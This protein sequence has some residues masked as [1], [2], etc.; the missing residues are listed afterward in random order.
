MT[1]LIRKV[2][3]DKYDERSIPGI[4]SVT[5]ASGDEI[6]YQRISQ[7]HCKTENNEKKLSS[8]AELKVDLGEVKVEEYNFEAL[9]SDCAQQLSILQKQHKTAFEE[10]ERSYAKEKMEIDEF[11]KSRHDAVEEEYKKHRKE[12]AEKYQG[13]KKKFDGR[14]KALREPSERLKI[15]IDW[16]RATKAAE[17][18]EAVNLLESVSSDI[19]L[20]IGSPEIRWDCFLSHVQKDSA[21]L[22]RNIKD[23][24]EREGLALWYDKSVDRVDNLGMI[25]GVVNSRVF[26]LIL[27]TE[28]FTRPYCVFEY[29][30]ATVAGKPIITVCE[31]DPRYG[32][33]PISCFKLPELFKHIMKH[34][35]IEINRTY[36]NAFIGKL[37]NRIQNTLDWALDTNVKSS[38][39]KDMEITWLSEELGKEGRVIGN[40]LFIA[41]QDG[42]T[43]EN[44]HSKCDGKGPTLTVI[45]TKDGHVFGGFTSRSWNGNQKWAC[46][47]ADSAWL[48]KL[49]S[50]RENVHKRIDIKPDQRRY[51]VYDGN[52]KGRKSGPIF[53]E[54]Y[55][56]YV[57]P[58]SDV[59]A[60]C[61]GPDSYTSAIL[62]NNNERVFFKIQE[63]EIFQI[64]SNSKKV[65]QFYK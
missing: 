14:M 40:R 65:I 19:L 29:C 5:F 22:C 52:F 7:E 26:I 8:T 16:L 31:S 30:V 10:S 34:E 60:Y 28:F 59:R 23:N 47:A 35:L 37:V 44:F 17:F 57:P 61:C 18:L 58:N 3:M 41:S 49:R 12:M 55:D 1:L 48:F 24:L 6:T 51:A 50:D 33:G 63:M 15:M 4:L 53:G 46:Y 36:W 42:K 2:L 13:L 62:P 32:G 38:I 56:I 11:W 64:T 20:K 21:D 45:Q 54:G 39:L 9:L 27:T 25:D 43:G